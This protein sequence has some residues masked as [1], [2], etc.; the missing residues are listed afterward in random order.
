MFGTTEYDSLS[1]HRKTLRVSCR[2]LCRDQIILFLLI[3][4]ICF[5]ITI[6]RNFNGPTHSYVYC[7]SPFM[8]Y[9]MINTQNLVNYRNR[10]WRV[11]Y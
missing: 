11:G 3:F 2:A 1:V 8:T 7:V 9:N 5:H 4:D 10:I 6:R